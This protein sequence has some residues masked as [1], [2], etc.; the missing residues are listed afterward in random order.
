MVLFKSSL[1]EII[2]LHFNRPHCYLQ[3]GEVCILPCLVK[4][5]CF[6]RWAKGVGIDGNSLE[7]AAQ[8]FRDYIK[9]QVS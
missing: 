7:T 1:L 8:H 4:Y 2:L 9:N 3:C 5:Y 6:C